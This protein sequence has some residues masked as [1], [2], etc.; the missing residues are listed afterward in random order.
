MSCVVIDGLS[1]GLTSFIQDEAPQ[2]PRPN[3]SRLD[4]KRTNLL[5]FFALK[6]HSTRDCARNIETNSSLNLFLGPSA[7][8]PASRLTPADWRDDFCRNPVRGREGAPACV[9]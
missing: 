1:H 5:T 3:I 7:A 4:A 8:S 9:L 6:E 2:Y